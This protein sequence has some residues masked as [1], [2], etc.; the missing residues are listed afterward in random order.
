MYVEIIGVITIFVALRALITRNRAEKLL[1]LNVIGFTVPA[2][3]AL[4]IDTPFALI[5]AAVF[6]VCSTISSNAIAYSLKRLDDE[7]ILD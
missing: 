5:V 4:V 1:Y 2:L 6:F 3:I 7:V